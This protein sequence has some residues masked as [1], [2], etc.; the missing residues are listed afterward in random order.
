M[1]QQPQMA[2]GEAYDPN[3]QYANFADNAGAMS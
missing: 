2:E 1:Q 3:K